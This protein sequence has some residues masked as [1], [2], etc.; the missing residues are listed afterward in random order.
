MARKKIFLD[1]K[2]IVKALLSIGTESEVS[3]F[4]KMQLIDI[5][6]LEAVKAPEEKKEKGSRGRMPHRYTL[7]KKGQ[8]LVRLSKGWFKN[9]SEEDTNKTEMAIAQ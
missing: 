3:R 7:T 5:G 2:A 4:H 9:T 6:H 1:N 8:N